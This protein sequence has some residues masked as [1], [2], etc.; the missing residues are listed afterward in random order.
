MWY[1]YILRGLSHPD[2]EYIGA[3]SDLKRRVTDHNNGSSYHTAKFLPW[4]LL[5][6]CAFRDKEDALRLKNI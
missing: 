6:Y 5:W 4:E 1:V 2:Q 3:T